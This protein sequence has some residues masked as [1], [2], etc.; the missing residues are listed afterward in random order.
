MTTRKVVLSLKV[1][2]TVS[3]ARLYGSAI[4]VTW[5]RSMGDGRTDVR[6]TDGD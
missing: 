6:Y 4:D 1:G 5:Y 3:T 2:C